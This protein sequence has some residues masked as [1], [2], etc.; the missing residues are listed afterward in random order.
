MSNEKNERGFFGIIIPEEILNDKELTVT[1]K[2][3]FGYIASFRKCCF[4]TNETI[5]G[6]LGVSQSTVSHVLPILEKKGYVFI[7][8]MKDNNSTR[9]IY[10]V[11][12]NPKKLEYLYKKSHEKACGKPCGKV[13]GVRQNMPKL[14]QNLHEVRQNMPKSDGQITGGSQA[15]FAYIDRVN[16][17]NKVKVGLNDAIGL[18]EKEPANCSKTSQNSRVLSRENFESEDDFEKAFYARNNKRL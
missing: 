6:R 3:I 4:Q 14:A 10:S 2:Y 11:L 5:A 15:K 7:E 16:K 1:E 13:G 18:A 12:E 8:K 17:K 9:R